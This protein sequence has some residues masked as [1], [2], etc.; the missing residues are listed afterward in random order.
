MSDVMVAREPKMTLTESLKSYFE[1]SQKH[2]S[3]H[4]SAFSLSPSVLAG[5]GRGSSGALAGMRSIFEQKPRAMQPI[6]LLSTAKVAFLLN[7]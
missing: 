6:Q 4:G 1:F 2:Y 7:K 5:Q 3:H